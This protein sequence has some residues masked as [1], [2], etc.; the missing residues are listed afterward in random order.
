MGFIAT[1]STIPGILVSFLTGSLSDILG[2]KRVLLLSGVF[3]FGGWVKMRK[4]EKC[5]EILTNEDVMKIAYEDG[6][7]ETISLDVC[8]KCFKKRMQELAV[9]TQRFEKS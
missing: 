5:S 6:S 8:P 2:R 9:R 4:C 7:Y 1:D 3:F